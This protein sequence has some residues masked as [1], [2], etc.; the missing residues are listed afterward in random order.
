MKNV[1]YLATLIVTT[2]FASI[3]DAQAVCAPKIRPTTD[4]LRAETNRVNA[5]PR[6]TVVRRFANRIDSIAATCKDS[7]VAVP[8]TKVVP[9]LSAVNLTISPLTSAVLGVSVTTDGKVVSDSAKLTISDSTLLS[10]AWG[11]SQRKYELH[12]PK[13]AGTATIT[14]TYGTATVTVPVTVTAGTPPTPT[15]N[16]DTVVTPPPTPNPDTTV[17]PTPTPTPTGNLRLSFKG[18]QP[19]RVMAG[20]ALFGDVTVNN[21]TSTAH[22]DVTVTNAIPGVTWKWADGG[23]CIQSATQDYAYQGNQDVA[24]KISTSTTTPVGSYT[25]T[26]TAKDRGTGEVKTLDVPVVV[27]PVVT[28]TAV[29]AASAPP[30]PAKTRWE[31]D[32]KSFGKTYCAQALSPGAETGVWYYDGIRVYH[33]IAKYLNDASYY[34]CSDNVKAMYLPYVS[35]NNGQIPLWRV[36]AQG[37]R[38]EFE[39]TGDPAAKSAALSLVRPPILTYVIPQDYSREVAYQIS[40]MLEA[41]LLGAPRNPK[42]ADYVDIALG[43]IDQWALSQ[44]ADFVRPFM[45]ALTAEALIKYH[46]VTGDPRVL[47]YVQQGADWMMAHGWDATT[48]AFRYT[49]R[50]VSTGGM[51]PTPDLNNLI[52]PVYGWVFFMT[53]DEKYRTWGDEI[54]TSGVNT[55]YLGGGKQYSQNYRWSFDYLKWTGR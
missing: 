43:H 2:A 15:P 1:F 14:L 53:G 8:V 48:K 50:V 32:M 28:P 36:F 5:A 45:F 44:T 17:T 23:C 52:V 22:V 20:S 18:T 55:G 54:F 24:Y 38:M 25:I 3:A 10:V 31:S 34:A 4:S 37:L 39:R 27:M 9:S 6:K 46:T 7:V 26:L 29:V 11:K 13:K 42:L 16:P 21:G 40:A 12:T 35:S 41:E 51:Q 30:L 19:R 47:W 49:D 33:N